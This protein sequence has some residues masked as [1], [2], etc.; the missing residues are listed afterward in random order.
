MDPVILPLCLLGVVGGGGACLYGWLVEKEEDLLKKV[1]LTPAAAL[2]RGRQAI[3]SGT[4]NSPAPARGPVS[5]KPCAYYQ[6]ELQVRRM[7]RTEGTWQVEHV[8]DGG[9]FFVED[10]GGKAFVAPAGAKLQFVE[11]T[12][13]GRE[14]A[15][16]AD[17]DTW[18]RERRI[19]LGDA[20]TVLGTPHSLVDLLES[21]RSRP[22]GPTLPAE[23]I[24][25]LLR[26]RSAGEDPPCFFCDGAPFLL[27]G[28]GYE[29]FREDLE[30]SANAYLSV[31]LMIAGLSAFVLAAWFFGFIR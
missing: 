14:G 24:D 17:G 19:E 2:E 13:E 5:G 16:F 8:L 25:Y 31:G 18:T 27:S 20:V 1:P 4:A 6:E 3:V 30:S 7:R 22:G 29:A 23:M 28:E 11:R 21:M 9:G 10:P 26:L 12:A 15:G